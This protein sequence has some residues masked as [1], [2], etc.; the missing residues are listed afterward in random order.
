MSLRTKPS[1]P[2]L[3]RSH[4]LAQGLVGTWAF[5]DGGGLRLT[6]LSGFS[7]HGTLVNG[8][9]WT[10]GRSGSAL[11]FDGNDDHVN[12][13]TASMPFAAAASLTLWVKLAVATPALEQT[14]FM[15]LG[16][17]RSHY[18]WSNGLGYFS[19]FR[20]SR[21]HDVQLSGS[22]DRTQWHLV[23]ITTAPGANGW[24]LYQ[25]AH[26]IH[27]VAGESSISRPPTMTIGASEG[28]IR[29]LQGEIDDIRIYNRA[30]S[31]DEIATIYADPWAIYRTPKRYWMG[32]TLSS[33]QVFDEVT[34]GG[35]RLDGDARIDAEYNFIGGCGVVVG[36][37]ALPHVFYNPDV[38][39]LKRRRPFLLTQYRL[40][41]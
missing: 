14:G 15:H 1:C 5:H 18:P 38:G 39:S 16:Q 22:V 30:L 24:K 32:A 19:E 26:L 6:D 12:V 2:V 7:N 41:R 3:Y 21:V 29:F 13:S 28:D 34:T 35:A 10:A 27:S 33:G 23:S 8:P 9:T 40:V 11:S 31:A 36:A 37:V 4:P 20:A 25:N 17:Q